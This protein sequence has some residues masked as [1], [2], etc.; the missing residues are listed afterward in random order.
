MQSQSQSLSQWHSFTVSD[1]AELQPQF[2]LVAKRAS[3]PD[4]RY[5]D[6]IYCAVLY[7]IALVRYGIPQSPDS[8]TDFFF[9]CTGAGGVAKNLQNAVRVR[10]KYVLAMF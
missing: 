9:S 4:S 5:R 7:S 3:Y 6:R 1:D 2:H 10:L 8:C